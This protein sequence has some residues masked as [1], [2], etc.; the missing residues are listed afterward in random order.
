MASDP[1]G[2]AYLSH[3]RSPLHRLSPLSKLVWLA[4]VVTLSFTWELSHLVI[5]TLA[6]VLVSVTLT[7]TRWAQTRKPIRLLLI[8]WGPFILVPPIAYHLQEGLMGLGASDTATFHLFGREVAYSLAGLWYGITIFLRGVIAAMAC[9]A[10][11]WTTHPRDVVYAL[12]ESARLPYRFAW[13]GFLA[14][15]YTPLILHEYEVITHAQAVRGL[16]N[17]PGLMG[18][19]DTVRNTFFPLL[20]R[21]LRKG[22]VT[23]LAMD[24]R[25]FGSG[26]VRV[27]RT[28]PPRSCLDG[29]VIWGSVVVT[30]LYFSWLLVVR[31]L[32]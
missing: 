20:V 3:T 15:I 32:M 23:S 13:A 11:V 22:S 21:G 27:F 10:M 9:L 25:G 14:L 24:S 28:E 30:V 2:L 29:L 8:I 19:V 17:R 12:T 5:L 6:T 26:P 31:P 1:I 18:M 4:C 16:R 7:G